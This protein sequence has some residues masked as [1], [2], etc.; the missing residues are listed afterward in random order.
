MMR[1]L[2]GDALQAVGNAEQDLG[3]KYGLESDHHKSEL[4]PTIQVIRERTED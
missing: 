2:T 3:W 1:Q 4:K